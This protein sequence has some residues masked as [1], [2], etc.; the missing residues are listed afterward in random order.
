MAISVLRPKI[1]QHELS[2]DSYLNLFQ[3]CYLTSFILWFLLLII[4]SLRFAFA[5]DFAIIDTSRTTK[6][7]IEQQ[8]FKENLKCESAI[9]KRNDEAN[10]SEDDFYSALSGLT[11]FA[12]PLLEKQHSEIA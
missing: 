1:K 10:K 4:M 7:Y 3:I 9:A 8:H 6:N 5:I 2:H 12:E 11:E